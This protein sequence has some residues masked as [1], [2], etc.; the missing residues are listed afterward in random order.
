[1]KKSNS[2]SLDF[3][4]KNQMEVLFQ[5]KPPSMK[6]SP[7]MEDESSKHTLSPPNTKY[8]IVIYY[9]EYDC[10]RYPLPLAYEEPNVEI[11]KNVI[12]TLRTENDQL[13]KPNRE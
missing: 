5:K 8:L 11:L 10:V 9:T 12:Q 13:R 7:L 3:I 2:V 4:T 1:M 6:G